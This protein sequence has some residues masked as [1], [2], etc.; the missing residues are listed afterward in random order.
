MK[1]IPSF[2]VAWTTN[3]LDAKSLQEGNKDRFIRLTLENIPAF[4]EEERSPPEDFLK[5]RVDFFYLSKGYTSPNEFWMDQGKDWNSSAEDYIGHR[6][7]IEREAKALVSQADEPKE[8]LRKLYARAQEIRNLSWEDAKTGAE[9]KR[10]KLKHNNN[11]EDVLKHG[12]GYRRQ[13]NL[14]FVGLARAAG[15]DAGVARVCERDTAF[16]RV[17]LLDAG[18]LNYELAVVRTNGEDR[19]FDPGTPFCPF[20][21]VHW[22]DTGV[23]AL[24]LNDKGGEFVQTPPTEPADASILRRADLALDEEGH[25]RGTIEI[26]FEGQEALTR[27]LVNIDSDDAD[28]RKYMEELIGGWLP[29]NSAFKL[30]AVTGWNGSEEPLKASGSVELPD[31]GV[32]TGKRLIVPLNLFAVAD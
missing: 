20:G 21:Q 1:P 11:I 6:K 8:K 31:F 14:F 32:S 15:F 13:I 17:N 9:S 16:F 26:V 12:Y 27:R 3:G 7:K 29:D 18:Q 10:E 24:R 22:S 23:P 30:E 5:M 4:V 2:R 28:R 19:Y 25:L